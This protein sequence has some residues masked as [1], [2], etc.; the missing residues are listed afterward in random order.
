MKSITRIGKG[1]IGAVV[2]FALFIGCLPIT[3]IPV[4]AAEGD[5]PATI[6]LGGSS[7]SSDYHMPIRTNRA[8]SVSEQIYTASEL[9]N[10]GGTISSIAF[11]STGA[12]SRK[13]RVYLA[14]TSK[15][16]IL[17]FT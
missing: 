9:G 7:T 12:A 4:L 16:C 2:S 14:D 17:R 3:A 11:Y 15:T 10:A 6:T 1:V 13:I 5:T 8:H